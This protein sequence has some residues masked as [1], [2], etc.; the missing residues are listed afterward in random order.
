M[1]NAVIY[2]RAKTDCSEDSIKSVS[3]QLHSCKA[4]ADANSLNIV[5]IYSDINVFG[6]TPIFVDWNAILRNPNPF[7]DCVLVSDYSRIGRNTRTVIADIK[8]LARRSVKVISIANTM[9]DQKLT[10]VVLGL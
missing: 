6:T 1:K 9:Q 3:V 4:Y 2:I 10:E 7:F 5:G 8:K